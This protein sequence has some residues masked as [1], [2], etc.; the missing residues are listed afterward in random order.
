MS[1]GLIKLRVLKPYN[2]IR[3]YSDDDDDDHDAFFYFCIVI[4]AGMS[5]V[6]NR[7]EALHPVAIAFQRQLLQTDPMST[8][9]LEAGIPMP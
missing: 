4:Q 6:L 8:V 2:P 9:V 7:E 1:E 5:N 3:P